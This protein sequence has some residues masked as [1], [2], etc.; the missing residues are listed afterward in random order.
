MA[1]GV[2][3]DASHIGPVVQNYTRP[4]RPYLEYPAFTVVGLNAGYTWP[5]GLGKATQT[6][7]LSVSNALDAD[8]LA[9]V[10]RVGAGRSLT[11]GWRVA[12]R[13]SPP[14]TTLSSARS[15]RTRGTSPAAPPSRPAAPCWARR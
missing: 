1:V 10:A 5:L 2:G 3:G 4:D 6:V 12:F 14:F 9:K 7:S 11:A 13:S 8:L 15:A